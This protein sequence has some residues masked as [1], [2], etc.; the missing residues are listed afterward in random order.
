MRRLRS[1]DPHKA[2]EEDKFLQI[3]ADLET[4]PQEAKA[5]LLVSQTVIQ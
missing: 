2:L 4:K 5:F 3:L 1:Q